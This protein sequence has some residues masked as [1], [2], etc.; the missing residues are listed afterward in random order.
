MKTKIISI[1]S[2]ASLILFSSFSLED[3]GKEILRKADAKLRGTTAIT[4][5]SI[6][7]VRPSW[8]R[9]MTMKSWS[10]GSNMAMVLLTSPIKE[11][12]IVFLKRDKE[13]WN[14]IPNIDRNIKLPPSMMGQSWMGTDF[15]NDDLV[16]ESSMINDYVHKLMTDET[17]EGRLCWKI[18]MIPLPD[19]AVVWGKVY[20]WIDKEEYM[21]LRTEFYDEDDILVSTMNASE[22]KTLG[23]KLL[24][25][26][27][28]MEPQEE[29]GKKTI[30]T[31]HSMEFDKPLEDRFFTTQNMKRVR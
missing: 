13:I 21:Q 23:G 26:K 28:V 8:T 12:G 25:T 6:K 19:A 20:T 2:I 3:D 7:I 11:K 5:M 9:E 27:L 22:V 24:P 16:K 14:W 30:M 4:E 10:K 15:T 29:K 31:Y 1:I 18:E 17:V